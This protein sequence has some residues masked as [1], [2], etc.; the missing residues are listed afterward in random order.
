MDH[1]CAI[2][3]NIHQPMSILVIRLLMRYVS[4]GNW[5]PC[6]YLLAVRSIE[7]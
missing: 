7:I 3:V 6:I 2:V 5:L 4:L 1:D